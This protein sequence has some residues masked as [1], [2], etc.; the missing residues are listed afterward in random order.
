[1]NTKFI[2]ITGIALTVLYGLFVVW[3]YWAAPKDFR[4]ATLKAREG[5]TKAVSTTQVITNTYEVDKTKFQEGISAFRSENY[6]L[7]RDRFQ[8]ADPEARDAKTQYYIAYSFYREGWGRFSNDDELFQKALKQVEVVKRLGGDFRAD[9][10]DL[11][12]ARPVE[13]EAELNDGLRVTA[14]DFNPLKV[15]R[16]RK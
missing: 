13:L 5:V 11:K 9:D 3:I 10:P 14:G 6:V 8:R 15:I 12:L 1:M 4:D 2:Q 16:E 7:A